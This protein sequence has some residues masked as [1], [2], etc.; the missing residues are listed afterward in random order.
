[1]SAITMPSAPHPVE[2]LGDAASVLEKH[3]KSFHFAG[4]L[5]N[6]RTLDRCAR[7]Y[8]FCRFVDDL[9]DDSSKPAE[10]KEALQQIEA[11]LRRGNSSDPHV[12]DFLDLAAEC[13]FDPAP[14]I[15]LVQGVLGDLDEVSFFEERDL[16]RYA[17]RVAG[18]VGLLMCGVFEVKEEHAFYH[19]ID[20]GMA[21]QFTNIA[22]DV[23]EDASMG[24][25]YLPASYFEK[26]PGNE[27]LAEGSPE[28]RSAIQAAV[29]RLLEK[30]EVYYRSGHAGLGYL[31]WRA[32]LGI[33]VAAKV[34]RAIGSK[35]HAIDGA[36]WRERAFVTRNRK[37]GIAAREL[38]RFAF[39]GGCRKL[40]THHDSTLHRHLDGLPLVD[41]FEEREE[42]P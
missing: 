21:M 34:Y 25:R 3:G 5:L 37:V 41:A 17:Y 8:R 35:I 15:A 38:L 1:M 28:A 10:A 27:A 31:P 30:A 19:A 2:P 16:D 26:V 13:G 40:P 9:G 7:L 24:R 32:R 11:E 39:S 20:L 29:E 14:A 12:S 23:S 4:Q 6:P 33:L 22:R 42:R 36:V 18:T